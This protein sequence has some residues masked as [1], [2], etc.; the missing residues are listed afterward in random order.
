M[1]KEELTR[2]ILAASGMIKLTL[3]V[4]NTCAWL[5]TL[6]AHDNI[7]KSPRYKHQIK[8]AFK[9]VLQEHKAYEDRLLYAT[10][11]RFFCVAD[12]TENTR[13]KFGKDFTDQ[14]YFEF[15]KGIGG[16]AFNRTRPLVTSLWN[17]YRKSL[18]AHGQKEA[19][20]SAWAF[21]AIAAL[22]MSDTLHSRFIEKCPDDYGINSRIAHTIFD[23]FSMKR[24]LDAWVKATKMFA[25]T[26]FYPLEPGEDR[27]ISLGLEQL[28]QAW[29]DTD[30]LYDSTQETI[31]D[32]DDIFRTKGEMK[33]AMRE[34]AEYKAE[35]KSY[36]E[37]E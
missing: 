3:G 13:K 10:T 34:I 11:N 14:Q 22:R 32:F 37:E 17:K 29:L 25:S 4:C 9:A 6:E 16:P 26:A 23:Q 5:V 18:L 7:R 12:M 8:Q 24:V 30:T 33:K 21:T 2:R 28:V 31:P 27:N 15:W 1:S 36:M 20:A 19:D 35:T